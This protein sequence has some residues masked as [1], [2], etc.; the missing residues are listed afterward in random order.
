MA[1]TVIGGSGGGGEL[2]A[3][4]GDWIDLSFTAASVLAGSPCQYRIEPGNV[5]RLRGIVV[6]Q[7]GDGTSQVLGLPL[8]VTA[9]NGCFF[10]TGG[11]D[12]TQTNWAVWQLVVRGDSGNM[13]LHRMLPNNSAGGWCSLDG[14][15]YPS[16]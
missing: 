3:S 14:T 11:M 4:F 6:A 1:G 16:S 10:I 5:V 13:D 7:F 2:V 15:V 12:E 8:P 9:P